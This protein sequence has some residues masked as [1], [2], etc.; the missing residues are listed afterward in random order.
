MTEYFIDKE[1]YSYF[2]TLHT[3]AAF[4]IGICAILATGTMLITYLQ[5]VCGLFSIAR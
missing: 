5:H 2:I 1:K 3:S 4:W